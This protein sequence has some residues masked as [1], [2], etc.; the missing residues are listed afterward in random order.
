MGFIFNKRSK[1]PDL[2]KEYAGTRNTGHSETSV[3]KTPVLK[4]PEARKFSAFLDAFTS[5]RLV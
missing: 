5:N 3:M 4:Q 1:V 2:A